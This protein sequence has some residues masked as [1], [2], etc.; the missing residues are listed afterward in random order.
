MQR[1]LIIGCSGAGKSTLARRMGEILHLPVIH[2]DCEYWKPGW[3]P[4]P[5]GDFDQIV[6]RL[7]ERDRWIMDGNF[8]RTLPSRLARADTVIHLV[9]SRW[10]CLW[11]ICNRVLLN[12]NFNYERADMAAGCGE[13]WDWEFIE[14]VWKFRRDVH[15]RNV[16][17]LAKFAQRVKV[18]TLTTPGE[19]AAFIRDLKCGDLT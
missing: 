11:R 19:V 15:P 7:I 18:V 13:Q 9:F 16:E 6:A 1:I 3:Q 12:C 5:D 8:G 14:W 2:L 10:R 17:M 4:T